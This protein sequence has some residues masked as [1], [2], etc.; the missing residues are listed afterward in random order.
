MRGTLVKID[1]ELLVAILEDSNDFTQYELATIFNVDQTT[2]SCKLKKLNLKVKPL[3]LSQRRCTKKIIVC[4]YCKQKKENYARG[5]C[6]SCYKKLK[7]RE[8]SQLYGSYNKDVS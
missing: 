1:E 6:S 5:L 4:S 7:D 2:I 3:S 8:Y